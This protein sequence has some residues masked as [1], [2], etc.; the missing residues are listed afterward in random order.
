MLAYLILVLDPLIL[1]LDPLILALDPLI[2]LL[3]LLTV[4]LL[5]VLLALLMVKLFPVLFIRLL[6]IKKKEVRYSRQI[7]KNNYLYL[8]TIKAKRN[9]TFLYKKRLGIKRL[10][11]RYIRL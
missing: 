4:E 3:I 10:K 2:L 1:A 7:N 5:R 9:R 11:P 6:L 8:L